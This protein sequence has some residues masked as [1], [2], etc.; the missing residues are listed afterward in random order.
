MSEDPWAKRWREFD[1]TAERKGHVLIR[2]EDG[3]VDH[4][5]VSHGYCNGPGCSVCGWSACHHCI[6]ADKIPECEG[7]DKKI[8]DNLR[9][10]ASYDE[11]AARLRAEAAKLQAEKTAG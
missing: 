4:F 9:I 1:E 11:R 10:A 2:N 8:A 7:V 6:T 3:D 5:V